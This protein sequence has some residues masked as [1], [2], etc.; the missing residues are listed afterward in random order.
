MIV[1]AAFAFLKGTPGDGRAAEIMKLA[2]LSA[3]MLYAMYLVGGKEVFRWEKGSLGER[4]QGRADGRNTCADRW[5]PR[6]SVP[7]T[8][9]IGAGFWL[10]SCGAEHKV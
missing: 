7:C 9:C 2:L 1:L 10:P 4:F 8:G 6:G 5:E 3:A